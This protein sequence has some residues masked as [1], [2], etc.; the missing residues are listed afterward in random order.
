MP[1]ARQS[2]AQRNIKH[3][4]GAF[5]LPHLPLLW[6][7]LLVCAS[8]L[9]YL[10]LLKFYNCFSTEQWMKDTGMA[11]SSQ[12][13]R[14]TKTHLWLPQQRARAGHNHASVWSPTRRAD[15]KPAPALSKEKKKM[16]RRAHGEQ[17]KV[18]IHYRLQ[19]TPAEGKSPTERLN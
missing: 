14:D 19:M 10:Q 15:P 17:S 9:F 1:S 3:P 5:N 7:F 18:T 6:K 12:G 16:E 13:T 11:I 2:T 4:S 8:L